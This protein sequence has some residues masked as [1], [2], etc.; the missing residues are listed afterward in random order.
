MGNRARRSS[1]MLNPNANRGETVQSGLN[2]QHAGDAH[3]RLMA[4]YARIRTIK[5]R[6]IGTEPTENSPA[7][8]PPA[9]LART[10]NKVHGCI[11]DIDGELD[12]I[13]KRL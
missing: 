7:P 10:L 8:E 11:T 13:E 2:E 9:N 5:S 1:E 4:L 3:G 12:R 6:L